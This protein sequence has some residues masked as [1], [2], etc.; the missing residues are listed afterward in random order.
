MTTVEPVLRKV[1]VN[2]AELAYW[3][4]GTRCDDRPSLY[5]VHATGFHGRVWDYHAE[6]FP[7]HHIVALEQRGHGR[8]EKLA[9]TDWHTFS[10]DQAAFVQALGLRDL[11]GIGHSM[12]AHGLIDGAASSGAFRRLVL[13]DP[14]VAAPEAYDE[15]Y[16]AEFG[17][18]LHPAAKRRNVYASVEDMIARLRDKSS[19]PL[20]HP[21]ILRDYCHY[22]LERI[23]S[24]EYVLACP[25][26]IE[27]HVYMSARTNGDVYD[28]ARRLEIPVT[29]VRAML[30]SPETGPDF[31]SSPTWPGLVDAFPQ[32]RELYWPDCTHFIPMQKPDEVIEVIRQE[33]V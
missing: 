15:D 2:G 3:E 26:E 33:A 25:P 32:G 29:I 23:E 24:G 4:R 21:R 22:G 13:L 9:V 18:E 19:F 30:P 28:S 16:A 1:K 7:E 27:A 31:S 14:T 11:I 8:S 12:G 20:F 5:F 6:A 10:E 17:D